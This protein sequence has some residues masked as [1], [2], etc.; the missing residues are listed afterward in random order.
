MKLSAAAIIL[1]AA[2]AK[3]ANPHLPLLRK[4]HEELQA[5]KEDKA[6]LGDSPKVKSTP[7]WNLH[8]KDGV[9]TGMAPILMKY[10]NEAAAHT[11]AGMEGVELRSMMSEMHIASM[12]VP[13][14][15]AK[16]LLV[17]MSLVKGVMEVEMDHLMVATPNLRLNADAETD[18]TNAL[19]GSDAEYNLVPGVIDVQSRS[20]LARTDL[21]TPEPITICVVDTG[22]S[23]GHANLPGMQHNVTGTDTDSGIALEDPGSGHGTH[24]SGTIGAIGGNGGGVVGVNP[25][26]NRFK[27]HIGKGLS[28]SGSGSGATVLAAV[29]GC[30]D[31]GAKVI[32]MSLGG[33]APSN[34][35]RDMYNQHYDN[36]VL[37]VAAAGNSG[38]GAFSYPASYEAV[39]SVAAVNTPGRNRASFSQFNSQL[40][41]SG[42]GVQVQSTSNA[43]LGINGIRTLSGTSM[44]CP[45]VAGVAALVWSY[46]PE[47]SND[48]I[49]T[50]LLMSAA[51]EGAVG[52]DNE[53]GHGFVQ[54]EA[55]YDL[56]AAQGCG[57]GFGRIGGC[58]QIPDSVVPTPAPT[59]FNCDPAE[60]FTLDLTTD[61]F[62]SETTWTIGAAGTTQASGSNYPSSTTTEEQWCKEGIQGCATFTINDAFGDGICCGFGQGGYTVTYGGEQVITGGDFGDTESTSFGCD[63]TAPAPPTTSPPVP[64]TTS[65]PVPSPTTS[66]PVPSPTPPPTSTPS[67]SNPPPTSS[68]PPVAPSPPVGDVDCASNQALVTLTLTTDMFPSETHWVVTNK[69]TEM[70]VA[71]PQL[72]YMDEMT[73]YTES[74]CLDAGLGNGSPIW[75]KFTIMDEGGDGL[76]CGF[77]NGGFT[78]E[79]PQ[80]TIEKNNGLASF[81]SEFQIPFFL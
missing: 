34:I 42:P 25:D 79:T 38:N 24:V 31:N 36:G 17:Q 52:C 66:P 65:P 21:R 67:S 16:E 19:A 1:C 47:C 72:Q 62:G 45:H 60:T 80:Q 9:R 18:S 44:A 59:P 29:Q 53:Y 15:N 23:F 81:G 8:L 12:L 7:K 30:V 22:Y 26:P 40:E 13:E 37:I 11:C 54:A 3:A 74:F 69:M 27:F 2:V 48:Q 76:C 61:V 5:K 78:L 43:D 50:A 73:T 58:A 64:P 6:K 4:I 57:V 68:L 33:P 46:F 28:N 49:R 10:E 32:S 55:A 77:G 71:I 35:A 70:C 20:L 14:E 63:A 41:I 75:Y 56:L 51:D 39:M